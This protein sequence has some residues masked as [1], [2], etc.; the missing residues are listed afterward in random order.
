MNNLELRVY[1]VLMTLFGIVGVFWSI[2]M[3]MPW[4]ALLQGVLVLNFGIWVW[5]R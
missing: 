2:S 5:S 3:G 4:L 1:R